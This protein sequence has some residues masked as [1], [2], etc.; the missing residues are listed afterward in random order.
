MN[1]QLLH[2]TRRFTPSLFF[3]TD[4]Q[5]AESQS[6]QI[7]AW[8]F[9]LPLMCLSKSRIAQSKTNLGVTFRTLCEQTLPLDLSRLLLVHEKETFGVLSA[10]ALEKLPAN[11]I[12]LDEVRPFLVCRISDHVSAFVTAINLSISNRVQSAAMS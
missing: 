4:D 6:G 8:N 3:S 11:V 10:L 12:D 5:S 7:M 1:P 2:C 9:T